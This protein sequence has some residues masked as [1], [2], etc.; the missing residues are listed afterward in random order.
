MSNLEKLDLYNH[1]LSLGDRI[2]AIVSKWNYFE[3]STLGKQLTRSADFISA[4]IAE[5]YGR[6][7]FKDRRQF[8]YFSR[9]SA[10]ETQNWIHKAKSRNLMDSKEAETIH[11]DLETI[12]K[13]INRY[14]QYINR[15]MN[16]N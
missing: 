5:G 14:I 13:M 11:E 6:F 7:H 2:W 12:I 9:G 10:F 1:S 3:K 16:G 8:C 4:N 15:K